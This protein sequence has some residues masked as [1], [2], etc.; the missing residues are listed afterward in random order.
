LQAV[1]PTC[2][3]AA[4]S[5]FV[6]SETTV[7]QSIHAHAGT[8]NQRIACGDQ[9]IAA[10]DNRR[11]QRIERNH[12]AT[13]LLHY[14]LCQ[15]VGD[16][17]KQAGSL[18]A[19]DRLRFDFTHFEPVTAEQLDAIEDLTNQLIMADNQ[20]WAET[21]SLE[22]ARAAGVIALFGEKYSD[23]VR[24][25]SAGQESKEL[26]GGTHVQHTA[27]IGLLK[28]VSE[29]SVGA[30]MRRIEAVT[31]YDALEF[32]KKEERELHTA[33]DLLRTRP[34]ELAERVAALQEQVGELESALRVARHA[35]LAINAEELLASRL[36]T[37]KITAVV[38]QQDGLDADELR[39]LW[40]Q[41]RQA[42]SAEPDYDGAAV[43]VVGGITP[44]GSPLLVAAATDA[45]VTKGFDANAIIKKIAPA[46]QGGGGGRPT[47]AQAG[48]KD[49]SGIEKALQIAQELLS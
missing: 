33:A 14:A 37:S 35:N 19:A 24:V 3:T 1:A 32:I 28:I 15:V 38:K 36:Q 34:A 42:L 7:H 25:L 44:N 2:D 9:V 4:K 22:A 48:G 30:S 31:S 40:D 47:M 17:V 21:T 49:P 6:V 12:T 27:Q 10:I 16:H 5:V 43:L 23:D 20:V 46:I 41:L 26:C 29:S 18:V 45:A 8:A 39:N 11:R 13:H